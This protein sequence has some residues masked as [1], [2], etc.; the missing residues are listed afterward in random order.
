MP[1]QVAKEGHLFVCLAC[2]KTSTTSYGFDDTG[3]STASPGW[4]E[5]C[6]LNAE[7]IRV[8]RLCWNTDRT[9][10]LSVGVDRYSP[11]GA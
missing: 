4:D 5:S 1:N 10:V 2:G 3:Q 9:R 8:D 11:R 6:M 7:E